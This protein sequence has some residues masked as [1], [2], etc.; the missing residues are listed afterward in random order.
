MMVHLTKK[1]AA[2][3]MVQEVCSHDDG[4]VN[5]EVNSHDVTKKSA[6]MMMLQ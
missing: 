3:M 5:K 4:I 1:P 6:A 2:T